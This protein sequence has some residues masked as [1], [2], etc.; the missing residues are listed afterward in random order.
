LVKN[1]HYYHPGKPYIDKIVAYSNVPPNIIALKIEKGE[2]DGFGEN[3]VDPADV[4]HAR[5]DPQFARYLVNVPQTVVFWLDLRT[6]VAPTNNLA[7]R[8]AVAM[9]INRA[10]L[11]QLLGGLARPSTQL[12]TPVNP[13]YDPTLDQHPVYP[14][15]PQKAAALVKTSG[16]HGQPIT[17]LYENTSWERSDMAQGIQQDLQQIGLNV[18]LRGV[19]GAAIDELAKSPTGSQLKPSAFTI[20]FPDA[21]DTY[22]NEATCG[23]NAAGGLSYAQYCDPTADK[24]ANEAE[25]LP[26]GAAR[27]KLLRQ[28]QV[29]ILRSASRVPLVFMETPV[30]VSPRVGGYYYNPIFGWQFENYWLTH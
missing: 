13:Q 24:L 27:D 2:L 17:L 21:Y 7:L 19:A 23:A 16:Y 5:S 6:H 3:S 22:G 28:A 26:L 18:T 12:Y 4:Q 9:A 10:H 30:M 29:R 8:Q 20:D 15:D 25:A 14:Y 11:V 1:T